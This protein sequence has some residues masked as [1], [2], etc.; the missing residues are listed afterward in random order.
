MSRSDN[1][2]WG[3][4]PLIVIIGL[5]ASIIAIVVFF[6]GKQSAQEF[7]SNPTLTNTFNTT[8]PECPADPAPTLYVTKTPVPTNTPLP[9]DT[10]PPPGTVRRV[11]VEPLEPVFIDECYDESFEELF[12]ASKP[13]TLPTSNEIQSL[14]L[15]QTS[16][17]C[18]QTKPSSVTHRISVPINSTWLWR[19]QSCSSNRV[20]P[21]NVIFLRSGGYGVCDITKYFLYAEYKLGEN[22]CKTWTTKL[23]ATKDIVWLI[24]YRFIGDSHEAGVDL[25]FFPGIYEQRFLVTIK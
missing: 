7:L 5:V 2:D 8:L 13:F 9:T 3:N 22:Y 18:A 14:P 4:K 6:S 17:S 12:G 10:P 1:T 16:E 25:W 20:F 24:Q 21:S 23:N 19:F 11:E 15:L